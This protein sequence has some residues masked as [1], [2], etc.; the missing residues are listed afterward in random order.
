MHHT[1]PKF[2][3]K[4]VDAWKVKESADGGVIVFAYWENCVTGKAATYILERRGA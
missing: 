1:I 4:I 2:S 3:R